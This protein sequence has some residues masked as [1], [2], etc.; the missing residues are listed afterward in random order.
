MFPTGEKKAFNLCRNSPTIIAM[1]VLDNPTDPN[2]VELTEGNKKTPPK[3]KKRQQQLIKDI[4]IT[5]CTHVGWDG[6]LV[7]LFSLVITCLFVYIT[8]LYTKGFFAWHRPGVWVF[9]VFAVL[10]A[11]LTL[12]YLF[13]WKKLAVSYS[14]I[15]ESDSRNQSSSGKVFQFLRMFYINGVLYLWKLYLFEFIESI[16]QLVNFLTV[17]LC[18]FET[19]ITICICVLLSTDAFYRAY[20][21]RQPN[22]IAQL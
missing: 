15:G 6:V 13:T 7:M 9:M 2:E 18:A 16:N 19:P 4:K 17:Y 1:D 5:F 22:T 10:Y 20:Q 3:R 8:F 14:T 11:L 21:L 12:M